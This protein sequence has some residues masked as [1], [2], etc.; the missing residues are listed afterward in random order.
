MRHFK[1]HLFY[2]P[3]TNW[4]LS[5]SGQIYC[6]SQIGDSPMEPMGVRESKPSSLHIQQTSDTAHYLLGRKA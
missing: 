3:L 2:N 6:T 1:I 5:L 4:A